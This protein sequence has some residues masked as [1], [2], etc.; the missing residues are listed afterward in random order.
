VTDDFQ[1]KNPKEACGRAL[2]QAI[3]Q[4]LKDPNG[5][6]RAE[7]LVVT[8][9]SI[10]GELCIDAA[11][12]FP[13]RTHEYP[14]GHRVFSDITNKVIDGDNVKHTFDTIP[15]ESVVGILR[16]RLPAA[17][18]HATDFPDRLEAIYKHFAANFGTPE[19]Q[20]GGVPFSVPE[21]HRPRV[22][23]WQVA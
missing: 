15:S 1:R 23:P 9:A 19:A 7:D 6:I 14:P 5:R 18:Y 2:M 12:I 3:C 11:G 20:A 10:V 22:L 13:S 16:D 8:T 21:A 17:G 4:R